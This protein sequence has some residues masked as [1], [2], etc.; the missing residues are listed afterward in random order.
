VETGNVDPVLDGDLD[1]F[2]E[3]ELLRRAK[4]EA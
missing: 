2:I 3:A 1:T 4:K